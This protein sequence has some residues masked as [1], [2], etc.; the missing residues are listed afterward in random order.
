[1]EE[2]LE[3]VRIDIVAYK[4]SLKIQEIDEVFQKAMDELDI[5]ST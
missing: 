5:E 2:Q 4:Y 3:D 1:L